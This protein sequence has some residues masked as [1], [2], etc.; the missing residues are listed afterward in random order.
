MAA[1]AVSARTLLVY[2]RLPETYR[3]YDQHVDYPLLR[4]LSLLLD[5]VAAIDDLFER[6]D[7]AP[8]DLDPPASDLADP[9]AA[10]AS[11]LPWL[12]QVLGVSLT[13]TIAEQRADLADPAAAHAHGSR[14]A[15][16]AAMAK[17]LTGTKSVTITPGFGG[18]PWVIGI[19]TLNAETD[20]VDTW[21][22]FMATYPDWAAVHRPGSWQAIMTPSLA[23]AVGERPAGFKLDRYSTG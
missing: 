18:D 11:W 13:G 15:L 23:A 20:T 2:D 10:D 14:S 21:A 5:Q 16:K 4:Y 12:A 6:L 7:R 8:E 9:A 17:G 3:D 19:G 22:E 1:P